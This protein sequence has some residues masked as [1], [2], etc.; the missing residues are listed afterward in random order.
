MY[1]QKGW[2]FVNADSDA[3]ERRFTIFFLVATLGL[4]LTYP[5]EDSLK[6]RCEQL[7]YGVLMPEKDMKTFLP[8][9]GTPL[10]PALAGDMSDFFKVPYLNVLV[11]ARQLNILS[12]EQLATFPKIRPHL[13]QGSKEIFISHDS[14]IADDLE[15]YLFGKDEESE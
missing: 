2:V 6:A 14:S 3:Y 10:T 1:N 7:I 9:D 13:G 8:E 11:R 4:H 5:V 15:S 12:E